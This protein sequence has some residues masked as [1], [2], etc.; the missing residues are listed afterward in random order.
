VRLVLDTHAFLWFVTNDPRLSTIAR[1][2]IADPANEILVS[3]AS[4]WEIAIKVKLGKY[5]LAVPYLTLITQGIDG[6]GFKI[7]AIEPKH[8][9]VLTTLPLH[10]RDPFDRLIVAQAMVEHV[11]V[12]SVDPQLDAYPIRRLW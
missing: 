1:A 10:H 11:P 2:L 12:V 5:V 6:N 4:Y 3:P 8:T 9:E 7:F